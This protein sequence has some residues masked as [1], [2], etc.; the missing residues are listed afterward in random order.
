M[1]CRACREGESMPG[2][3]ESGDIFPEC[4]YGPQHTFLS[5]W[6]LWTLGLVRQGVV[7]GGK[8]CL[9]PEGL[10]GRQRTEQRDSEGPGHEVWVASQNPAQGETSRGGQG[11]VQKA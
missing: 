7:L 8:A 3:L 2:L 4:L 1:G 6:R 11:P 5:L 10:E 9:R